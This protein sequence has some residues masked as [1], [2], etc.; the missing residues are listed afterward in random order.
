MSD[1]FPELLRTAALAL[2][3]A[4]LW[5]G[6]VTFTFEDT[7]RRGFSGRAVFGW[8]AIVAILPFIGL[9]IY[10][11]YLIASN[12]FSPGE[13]EPEVRPRRITGYKRPLEERE[14]LSTIYAPDA[15]ISTGGI[16]VDV[17]NNPIQKPLIRSIQVVVTGGPEQGT[18][19]SFNSLPLTIGR[20][21]EAEIPLDADLSV[22]RKHASLFERDGQV[23]IRDLKS[24]HGTQVNGQRVEE[25]GLK[26]GDRVLVGQS[27]LLINILER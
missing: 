8:A 17:F 14:R 22:S 16:R 2:L 27:E 7:R 24:R 23:S 1:Q 15:E 19:F 6:T 10:L 5:A 26:S 21:Y 4:V 13:R 11:I 18:T 25:V 3:I 20:G 9:F 12:L